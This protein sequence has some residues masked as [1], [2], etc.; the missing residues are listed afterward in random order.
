[1]VDLRRPVID[2]DRQLR[3]GKS[4][5][6]RAHYIYALRPDFESVADVV[7]G[8]D[9]LTHGSGMAEEHVTGLYRSNKRV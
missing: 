2:P 8:E 7:D 3:S 6:V 1:M 9:R 4:N 5:R